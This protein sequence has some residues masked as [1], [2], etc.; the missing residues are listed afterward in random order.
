MNTVE[1]IRTQVHRCEAAEV[2]F[3][4]CPEAILGGLADYS[5]DRRA[6]AIDTRRIDTTLAPLASNAVAT[7]VGFT[8]SVD[9]DDR[10]YN[11]AAVFH[12]GSVIGL[13][14]K[15]HPAIRKSAYSAGSGDAPVFEIEGLTFGVLICNDSNYPELAR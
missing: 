6:H 13:Y 12:R 7:I 9:D 4:C 10:L 2:A 11:S 1:L 3:L 15:R 5:R 8:E 14:R